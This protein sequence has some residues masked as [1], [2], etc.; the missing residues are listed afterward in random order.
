MYYASGAIVAYCIDPKHLN[1]IILIIHP[2]ENDLS[3]DIFDNT[4][5]MKCGGSCRNECHKI[6]RRVGGIPIVAASWTIVDDP[7]PSEPSQWVVQDNALKQLSN[8]YRTDREYEFYQG[9]H[10]VA[11]S[12]DWTDYV[13]SFDMKSADNDGIGAIVR[14]QDKDNYYRFITVQD[15]GNHG[16]FR[17]FEKFVNGVRTVLAEDKIGYLSVQVYHMQFKAIG[18]ALEVWMDGSKILSAS[19]QTFKSGKI[20]FLSYAS[21]GLGIAN[22]KVVDQYGN[23]LAST[24]NSTKGDA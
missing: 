15:S 20:G 5:G 23:T 16:P 19:D 12:L 21:K 6:F 13:L 8:I 10:I 7:Y 17:R 11:G 2:K 18:N 3:L 4:Y 24:P 9:T 22:V 14:Y 1:Q